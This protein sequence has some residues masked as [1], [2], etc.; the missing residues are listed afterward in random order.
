M[1]NVLWR[2]TNDRR[3]PYYPRMVINSGFWMGS[4]HRFLIEKI[5][6]DDYGTVGYQVRDAATVTDADIRH[7]I[8]SKVVF[9][10]PTLDGIAS[11]MKAV[12]A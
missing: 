7:G 8:F 1:T 10:A 9:E 2:L 6:T 4:G 12:L 3:K 11:Y 5:S